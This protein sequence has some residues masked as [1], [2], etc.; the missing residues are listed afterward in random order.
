MRLTPNYMYVHA[1][2]KLLMCIL[3]DNRLIMEVQVDSVHTYIWDCLEVDDS[4]HDHRSCH[5]PVVVSMA[6]QNWY[7]LRAKLKRSH[8]KEGKICLYDKVKQGELQFTQGT[9]YTMFSSTVNQLAR[10]IESWAGPGSEA[11]CI[12][13]AS[14]YTHTH[15]LHAVYVRDNSYNHQCHCN[16]KPC[17]VIAYS[18]H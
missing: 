2:Q 9:I 11:T 18:E 3:C 12:T 15:T 16:S 5:L 7:F 1:S 14:V 6:T 13:N 8:T 17:D 10:A 4:W